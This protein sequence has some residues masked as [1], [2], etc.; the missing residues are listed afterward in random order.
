MWRMAH[1]TGLLPFTG[2]NITFIEFCRLQLM[3]AQTK[4]FDRKFCRYRFIHSNRLMALFTFFGQKISMA[5]RA[6]E[7]FVF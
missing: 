2:M 3:A 4:L 7:T 6:E 5:I 1:R